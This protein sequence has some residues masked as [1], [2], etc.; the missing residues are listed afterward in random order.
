[1]KKKY[2]ILLGFIIVIILNANREKIFFSNDKVEKT[3]LEIEGNK[4]I[5]KI[6]EENKLSKNIDQEKI[7]KV[8]ESDREEVCKEESLLSENEISKQLEEQ[9]SSEWESHEKEELA[10]DEDVSLEEKVI[11]ENIEYTIKKG[12][13]IYDLSKEYKIK[14]DYIYANNKDM[15]LSILQIG[16]KINI[17]TEN[18]IFYEIQ[19]GDTLEKISKIFEVDIETIKKDN[20]IEDL[21][22]LVVG[23]SIFIREPKI[24]KYMIGTQGEFAVRKIVN[25]FAN[26]LSSMIVTSSYGN[27]NHPV[28]KKVLA[29]GGLDLR[30]KTGTQVMSSKGGVVTYA[31]EARG[32]GKVII[33]KHNNGYETR[34]AH[35]SRIQVK[36]GQKV[37]QN[38]VI[39][40]SGATGRV[41]GPH[42]HFEIR[43]NGKVENP[44][45]Y[46]QI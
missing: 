28:M 5:K 15:N 3:T 13:T 18:G 4:E 46:L 30:A 33:I 25:G 9:I 14:S 2:L 8:L 36:T 11:L 45:D 20:E 10:Y 38:Q 16:K 23:A 17:P 27:R 22:L 6:T 40:L 41:T 43:K 7:E 29:H 32:Y 34:Y 42:L 44:L 19:K 37:N 21:N 1:M 24:S 26:P 12:D 31:G 35:L 39:G